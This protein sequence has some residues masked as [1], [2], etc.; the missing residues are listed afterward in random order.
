MGED[1]GP[2]GVGVRGPGCGDRVGECV[3]WVTSADLGRQGFCQGCV[4][5]HGGLVWL[6][7]SMHTHRL[8]AL[9]QLCAA[10]VVVKCGMLPLF[11][12]TWCQCCC[13]ASP[14]H[15]IVTLLSPGPRLPSL[16][17]LNFPCPVCHKPAASFWVCQ[18]R[19]K[20]HKCACL[21]PPP[22]PLTENLTLVR[23]VAQSGRAQ[24]CHLSGGVGEDFE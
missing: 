17:G 6:D 3:G 2:H 14:T 24:S 21:S 20:A 23:S 4:G 11:G 15:T 7:N 16:Q 22:A 10:R 1:C 12:C 19:L 13:V 8:C 5:G 18:S 9:V